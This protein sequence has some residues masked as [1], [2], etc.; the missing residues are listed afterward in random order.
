MCEEQP[1]RVVE[2]VQRGDVVWFTDNDMTSQRALVLGVKA[3]EGVTTLRVRFARTRKLGW[4]HGQP[5]QSYW[6][7]MAQVHP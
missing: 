2:T 6:L 4:L 5:G 7:S 1:H 3:G